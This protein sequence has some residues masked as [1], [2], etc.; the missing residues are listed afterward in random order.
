MYVCKET[1]DECSPAEYEEHCGEQSSSFEHC[2]RQDHCSGSDESKVKGSEKD[3]WDCDIRLRAVS[4]S[5]S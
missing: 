3:I 1:V 4:Q 2:A 5:V